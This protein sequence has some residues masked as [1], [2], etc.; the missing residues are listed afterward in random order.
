MLPFVFIIG[1][2]LF[3][4]LTDAQA[5]VAQGSSL[6]GHLSLSAIILSLCG[7]EIAGV[8]GRESRDGAF[9]KAL[10]L[11]V[12]IIV[13][14]SLF[15]A[16]TIHRFIPAE[17]L[18]LVSG[19]PQFIEL[20]LT[21]IHYPQYVAL[22]NSL[23]VLGCIGCANNWL[24]AP[25]KGLMFACETSTSQSSLLLVQAA[26]VSLLSTLFLF[27]REVNASYWLMLVLA[28]QMYLFMYA[29]MFVSA[30][31]LQWSG[32]QYR[33]LPF[34][35]LGLATVLVLV[36][37][38]FQAPEQISVRSPWM[39]A[40]VITLILTALSCASVGL[41]FVRCCLFGTERFESS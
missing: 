2:G 41:R 33:M 11:S 24:I 26:C 1:A 16:L 34:S 3:G 10:F 27:F 5:P 38:G 32:R 6:H 40:S 23:V 29:L 19:I 9:V 18:S 8:H 12:I 30:I 14:S 31:R 22:F 25:V 13:A 28:T 17:Q 7:M 39:Y 21:R 15:G 4:F 36:A 37:T 35:L 20:V